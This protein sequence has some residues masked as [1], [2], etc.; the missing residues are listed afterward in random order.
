LRTT[1]QLPTAFSLLCFYSVLLIVLPSGSIFGVNFKMIAFMPVAILAIDRSLKE[2]RQFTEFAIGLFVLAVFLGWVLLSQADPQFDF[3]MGLV[4]YKD[5]VTTLAGCWFIRVFTSKYHETVAFI[6]LCVFSVTFSSVLKLFVFIYTAGTG[7]PVSEVIIRISKL[8][9]VQ[10]LPMDLGGFFGRVEFTSDTLVPMCIFAVLCIRKRLGIGNIVS[11]MMVALFIVSSFFTFSRVLWASAVIG[12]V[13]GL[14]VASKDRMHVI[15]IGVTAVAVMYYYGAISEIVTLR[16]SDQQAGSSDIERTVQNVALKGFFMD[17]PILGHGLGSYSVRVIRS[18][19]APYSYE[20]QVYALAGQVGL[21]G[22]IFFIVLIANYYRKAFTFK[23]G[24]RAY[25][26][27][28]L[29]LLASYL[30]GG[31]VN[32]TLLSSVSSVSYGLIFALA[33]FGRLREAK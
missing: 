19:S 30:A 22:T 3:A 15:Y 29:C 9:G 33:S 32:P 20:S 18:L 27:A 31:F 2:S 25:E 1:V 6:R 26:T 5:V 11:L 24:T 4:Q 17:A 16:F 28:V 21:V 10:A 23:R 8:F 7:V 14:L 12:M 13:L